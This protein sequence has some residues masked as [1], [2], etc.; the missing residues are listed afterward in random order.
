MD[1]RTAIVIGAT[2][3]VGKHLV[4]LL[5]RDERFSSVTVLVRR[6]TGLHH[7]KLKE[8]LISFDRPQ[9]WAHLVTGDVLFS[10]LGTTLKQAGSQKAQYTVDHDYQLS[11]AR[12]AALNRVPVY[13]LVSAAF[14]SVHSRVF[15]SRMKGEL[16]RDVTQLPFDRIHIIQ[17]GMLA[18]HRTENRPF[19]KIGIPFLRFLNRMGIAKKQRPIHA[20][21]VAQA[22]INVSFKTGPRVSTYSLLEVF[23]QAGEVP[24]AGRPQ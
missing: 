17:P 24:S 13:V 20:S 12:A 10:A 21:I 15:Y 18:G 3:L 14:A 2:G 1:A 4:E 5:L 6:N 9:E 19:E 7:A 16:E 8:H 23:Q 11:V 22:M